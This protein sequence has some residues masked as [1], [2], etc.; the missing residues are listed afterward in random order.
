VR[1]RDFLDP[2]LVLELRQSETCLGCDRLVISRWG[3]TKKFVCSIGTQKAALHI[4]DMR[5]CKKYHEGVF[6]TLDQSAQ[7]EELLATWYKWQIRQSH[8]ETL[9]HFYR[10]EDHTCRGYTTPTSLDEPDEND[11]VY[12]WA[13]DQQSE[14]VQLCVDI[15]PFD[16]RAAISNSMRNKEAGRSVW[17]NRGALGSTHDIYQE[18]K[19]RLLPMLVA[20]QLIRATEAV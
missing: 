15:L 18:A 2:A 9:S 4:D 5:R 19:E 12:Q 11:K 10:P 13:D 16:Q 17:A 8:A 7:I 14:Q 20:R 6:M 3:G 1:R